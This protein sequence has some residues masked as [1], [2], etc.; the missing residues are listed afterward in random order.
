M[1]REMIVVENFYADPDAVVRHARALEYVSPYQQPGTPQE[2]ARVSWRS[3]RYQSQRE[4]PFKSSRQLIAR[5]EQ[6][7]GEAV[8][9]EAW[10]WEFPV[11]ERGYPAKGYQLVKEKSAWWHCSFHVKHDI[12]QPLGGGVHNH[13]DRDSWNSVGLDGWAGLIYLNKE[14]SNDQ[15]GLRTW[16][17]KDPKHQFDW[18][19]PKENWILQDTLANAYNRM[20]LHRGNIPHSGTN[21]WGDSIENGRF[22]Q[23]FFFRSKKRLEMDSITLPDLGLP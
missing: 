4:C 9:T 19:T 8:D 10:N 14:R 21:G 16:L 15:A 17:N 3:S 20:I 23:T 7:T 12:A 1:K 2:G 6:I 22:Y 18:M 13:T 5:L 11:D